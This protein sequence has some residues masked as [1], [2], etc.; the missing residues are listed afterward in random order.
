MNLNEAASLLGMSKERTKLAI[1]KGVETPR[2]RSR[3]YLKAVV[4]PNDYDV[5]QDDVD[6]LIAAFEKE[7]P[8]RHPPVAVRRELLI[9]SGYKCAVCRD[10]GPLEFHHIIEW[11]PIR[12][13]DSEHM[14]AVCANCHGR[15]TR[16][17]E[18]DITAQRQIKALR[19]M[20]GLGHLSAVDFSTPRRILFLESSV[21]ETI[22]RRCA[23]AHFHDSP[24]RL[25]RFE[26]WTCVALEGQDPPQ[27]DILERILPSFKQAETFVVA[28]ILDRNYDR[29]PLHKIHSGERMNRIDHV[30]S[31]LTI[32][33]LFTQADTLY[34][35]V[36]ASLGN[37]APA[38][39]RETIRFAIAAANTDEALR[40]DAED[41]L[42]QHF[43]RTRQYD[44]KTAQLEA[45]RRVRADPEIWQRGRDRAALILRHVGDTL[46]L[47]LQGK[48]P[49][50]I[51]KLLVSLPPA[52]LAQLK[53]PSEVIAVLDELVMRGAS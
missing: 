31:C 4:L 42:A 24:N 48:L 21:D 5:A 32:E 1:E 22:L 34:S 47:P 26:Q 52:A 36:T 7:E 19:R 18:P 29:E 9:E 3:I 10:S 33:S 40:E 23:Q 13:H 15:I 51:S 44:G 30:W 45:R 53:V 27:A 39:I 8:G 38:Q 17:G 14:L 12:H 20:P 6:A 50:D 41:E 37:A 11:T 35:L 28:T 16:Y 49:T 43:R 46:S 2:T 25:A